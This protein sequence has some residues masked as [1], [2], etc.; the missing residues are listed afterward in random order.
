[1]P[2]LSG[3]EKDHKQVEEGQQVPLRPCAGA[4]EANNGQLS[5]TLAQIVAATAEIVDK[6][7][8]S[9]CKSTDELIHGIEEEVN[10]QPNIKDLI[11]FSSDISPQ[12]FPVSTLQNVLRWRLMS[13]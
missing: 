1:M 13:S 7:V 8:K 10:K 9:M 3:M 5:H 11:I 12:C 4:D 2:V 6:E